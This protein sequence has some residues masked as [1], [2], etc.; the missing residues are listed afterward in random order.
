[1]M[2]NMKPVNPQNGNGAFPGH[3]I[4]DQNS[5]FKLNDYIRVFYKGRWVILISFLLVMIAT[6]YYTF[7]TEPVY[8]AGAKIMIEQQAG[9]GESLFDIT[10]MMKKETMIN[11]QVEIL[12]SRTLAEQVIEKLRS[13][14]YAGELR[15]LGNLP[16]GVKAKKDILGSIKSFIKNIINKE[17]NTG[18]TEEDTFNSQVQEL[19][20][21]IS[22]T[23][24]R[25][26]DMIEIKMSAFSPKE[27]AYLTNAVAS[28][29]ES[30]N[31]TQSQ[32]EVRQ[33]K[34]FLETQ[35]KEYERDLTQSEE[36]LKDYRETAKVVALDQET[37]ELISK[38]AEFETLYNEAKTDMEAARQRLTYIDGQL[39]KQQVNLDM[40]AISSRPYLEEL[41]RQIAEK[42]VTLQSLTASMIMV[43]VNEKENIDIQLQQKQ[44]DALKQKFKEEATKIAATEFVDPS[45]LSGSLVTSKIEVE[46]ELQALKPKV[47]ELEKILKRYNKQLDSLPEKSLKLA[48]LVRSAQV[49]EKIYIML[50]EKY[51]ESRITEVGQLGNVRIIDWAKEPE[52]PVKPK[53]KVNLILGF[54]LGL[55][56]G[57]GIAFVMDYLDNSINTM[58]DVERLRLPL[59]ATIPFI[60]PEQSNGVLDK[61]LTA[62]DEE[63]QDINERLITHLKPKS[64]ISE[65]YRT[66]RTN[67]T[68]TAPDN[69]KQVIMVTSSGP[70][71]GKSTSI[72]NLAITFAQMGTRT[73]LIDSDLRRPMLHKLFGMEKQ[74]GLTNILVG[75]DTL[76]KAVKEVKHLP[77]LDILTCGILPPN[78]AELLGSEQMKQLLIETKAKYGMVL[79]DTPPI[80]AVTDSSVLST[81][82]D[83]VILVIRS[84]QS[85]QDTVIHALE[86]LHRVEAPLLGVLLN[87]IQVSNVYG[88]YYYYNYYHYYYGA[89]GEKKKKKVE[90]RKRKKNAY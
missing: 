75:K 31:Q 42:E 90:R 81:M 25:N 19:R 40:E 24:I 2:Q 28:V 54:F 62:E 47:T 29:Y 66:L 74:S 61:I 44:I 55:G 84:G 3:S 70:K 63:A 41:R 72:S 39:D 36:D 17:Q 21:V 18:I 23:P 88:S 80:I 86:Q 13:S 22:I 65:A 76:D 34:D 43:G 59:M 79:I 67:I 4:T 15:I 38:L 20:N 82:V 12:K 83:G 57:I 27:A 1:M 49:Q 5:Q 9:V 85:K 35:L 32:A 51:Q 68:F 33:V 30:T 78:P 77:N 46:T 56:L 60:K 14:E 11:N 37:Q 87:G 50:Q 89:D 69:P 6:V 10:S 26:T 48:R 64:P 16:E 45:I 71:E 73:L 58:E 53:K 52:E 7:T 8:E